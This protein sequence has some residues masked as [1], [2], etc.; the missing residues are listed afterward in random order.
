MIGTL[1]NT[2]AV[3]AGST[4][5]LLL[6]SRLPERFTKIV[7]QAFGLFTL[8][9]GIHMASKTTHFLIMIFSILVG[10]LSGELLKLEEHVETFSNYLKKKT[11]KLQR[12]E[13][14]NS[15]FTEGFV[16]AFILFCVGSMTILGAIE[17]GLG[18]EPNLLLAKS[19]LD[20]FA[21]IALASAFGIGV[22]FSI[23]PLLIY[24]G[25]LTLLAGYAQVFFTPPIIAELTAVGGLLLMGLGLTILDIKKLKILNMLPSLVVV[26]VL[27]YIFL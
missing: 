18:G 15:K 2:A 12:G 23:I 26:V 14:G 19:V 7:F 24:Q 10:S 8:F 25:G 21:S 17:E 6:H 9:L 16:T 3:I 13:G 11:A 20:G 5:G 27:S 1:I 22:M 4:L